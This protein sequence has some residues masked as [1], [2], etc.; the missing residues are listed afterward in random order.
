M[1]KGITKLSRFHVFVISVLGETEAGGSG[2]LTHC[3][4][5]VWLS[6]NGVGRDHLKL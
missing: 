5:I 2:V 3:G 4:Y 1:L 6:Q